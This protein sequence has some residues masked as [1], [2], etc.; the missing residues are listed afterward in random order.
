MTF[1]ELLVKYIYQHKKVSLEGFGTVTL[2]AAVPDTEMIHKNRHI[3]VEGISFE[4]NL[5][6]VTD[7]N[8]VVFFAQQKGKIKPL[9]M[10]DIESH[11]QLARQ[12]MNIGN[13][14]QVDGLG[15]FE[16]QNNGSVLLLPGHYIVPFGDNM[17]LPGRMKE[18]AEAPP[19]KRRSEEPASGSSGLSN[20]AKK[21]LILVAT[22]LI[23]LIAG[24]FIWSKFAGNQTGSNIPAIPSADSVRPIGS[25]DTPATSLQPSATAV[26]P[27]WKAYFRQIT[28]KQDALA[29]FKAYSANKTVM[30]ETADSVTFR[31]YVL[32]ESPVSDTTK[33]ID[34]LKGIFVRP[35][36]LERAN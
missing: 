24:W 17:A 22:V 2:S 21:I 35:I 18:R 9:A 33:K 27:Q 32:I 20:D 12:L 15:S 29:K 28:E 10:S 36:K 30:M 26:V 13:P 4:H 5:K 1:E 14:Y 31:L 6:A 11:L 7:E 8:F 34:S 3:A 25:A 19:E 23:V 16:K